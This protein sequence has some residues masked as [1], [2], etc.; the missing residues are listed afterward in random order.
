MID[1]EKLV[2]LTLKGELVRGSRL[3]GNQFVR[4]VATSEAALGTKLNQFCTYIY[5]EVTNVP[6]EDLIHVVIGD[7]YLLKHVKV[8]AVG[9]FGEIEMPDEIR[10]A[11]PF[12]QNSPRRIV[13][14]E[15]K[16]GERIYVVEFLTTLLENV[17][18]L[19]DGE[20]LVGV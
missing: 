1:V 6:S 13:V 3:L 2:G 8:V 9:R 5:D 15:T 20:F 17:R 18:H 10:Q 11:F 4:A 12:P 14:F 7:P 16:D 19:I